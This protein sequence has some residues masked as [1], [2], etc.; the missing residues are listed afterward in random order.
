MGEMMT[1]GGADAL[2]AMTVSATRLA[3][4]K[5]AIIRRR[6]PSIVVIL[7]GS[8]NDFSVTLEC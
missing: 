3:A 7:L 1:M 5:T 6:N 4:R 2:A 8:E